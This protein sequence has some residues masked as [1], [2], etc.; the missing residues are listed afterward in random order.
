M[1]L[2]VPRSELLGLAGYPSHK[3]AFDKRVQG[4]GASNVE[5]PAA[6]GQKGVSY[7]LE[8][9]PNALRDAYEKVRRAPS[10]GCELLTDGADRDGLSAHFERQSDKARQRAR[11]Q[12][13]VLRSY[14]ELVASGAS[15]GEARGKLQLSESRLI[16]LRKRC[17]DLDPRD[18][19]LALL[20]GWKGG[21]GR[22]VTF[23]AEA[24]RA[25]RSDYLRLEQPSAASCWRRLKAKAAQFGW[26]LPQDVRVLMRRMRRD[27]LPQAIVA[28]RQG[29]KALFRMYPAQKRDR[30]DLHALQWINVDGHTVDN[31][32]RWPDGEVGRPV[33]ILVQDLYSNKIL[34]W[35]VDKSESAAA[36]RLALYD[37][38]RDWGIPKHAVLDNGRAFAS[39]QIT[40]G[41]PSRYRFKVTADEMRGALTTL[42]VEVHWTLPYSGQ[43][44]PIE[45]VFRDYADAV[46]RGPALAGS[47]TS[48]TPGPSA[49]VPP[50]AH[51]SLINQQI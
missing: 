5:G 30:S 24:E 19:H 14:D 23:S 38:F 41:Q 16:R 51:S 33:L 9:L 1:S 36:V 31:L 28:A 7:A 17:K 4:E 26:K 47:H 3:T 50:L 49:A 12:A 21:L 42:G 18:W 37:T 35:R 46:S 32:I 13:D 10:P 40:G 15:A 2:A 11:E 45:R 29:E 22:S 34:A 44:K 6:R 20:P 27:L 39:K 25:F 8:S 43:S 48:C